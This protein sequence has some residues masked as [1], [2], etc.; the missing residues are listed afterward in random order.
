MQLT[1]AYLPNCVKFKK[2]TLRL[3]FFTAVR[4]L[5]RGK[6]VQRVFELRAVIS[7]FL[8]PKNHFL[9]KYFLDKHLLARVAYLADMF[10]VLCAVNASLQGRDTVMFEACDKL[11][12]F[13]DNLKLWKIRV[14][15]GQLE[16]FHNLKN[17][18]DEEYRDCTFHSVI[19]E[20]IDILLNY[21]EQYFEDDIVMYKRK[22]WVKFPFDQSTLDLILDDDFNIKD[23]FISLRADSTLKIEFNQV[24][25]DQFGIRRL[26][27]YP[28]LAYEAIEVLMAFPTSWECEAAFSQI[29]IIKTKHRN[30]LDV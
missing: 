26:D 25:V 13:S 6:V 5:S 21:L 30:R 12:A 11:G 8:L 28:L 24:S 9:A 4:W 16:Y 29:S 20:H 14:Q 27:T 7:E 15:R 19:I 17:F 2:L 3:L 18:I 10:S 22:Q 23:E 1:L